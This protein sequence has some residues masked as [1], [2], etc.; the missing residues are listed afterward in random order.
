MC[1]S[2]HFCFKEN[3]LILPKAL[4]DDPGRN[5]NTRRLE[6]NHQ[7]WSPENPEHRGWALLCPCGSPG[8]VGKPSVS[9][10]WTELIKA[11]A[12]SRLPS[13]SGRG[14]LP[15]NTKS[16]PQTGREP[17][18]P[19]TSTFTPWIPAVLWIPARGRTPGRKSAHLS[20]G[21]TLSL[22]WKGA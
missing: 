17:S 10:L 7:G 19:A 20:S 11:S 18:A 15:E 14:K 2:A 3:I 9:P 22:L 4:L 5:C 1:V 12:R 6:L 21:W 8:H 16:P 13:L